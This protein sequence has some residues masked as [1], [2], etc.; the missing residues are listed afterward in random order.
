M[1]LEASHGQPLLRKYCN[2]GKLPC[3]AAERQSDRCFDALNRFAGISSQQIFACPSVDAFKN[4]RLVLG[5]ISKYVYF[6]RRLTAATNRYW[7]SPTKAKICFNASMLSNRI[8]VEDVVSAGGGSTRDFL[9]GGL[10]SG[11]GRGL[12]D[13]PTPESNGGVDIV[14]LLLML[15]LLLLLLLLTMMMMMVVEMMILLLLMS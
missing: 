10:V 5:N 15:L 8:V 11:G 6:N 1:V 7:L 4:V 3:D 9:R 12:R 13:A 2:A 14:V